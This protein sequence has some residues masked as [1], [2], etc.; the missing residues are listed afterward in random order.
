[1]PLLRFSKD[2][3]LAEPDAERS[4]RKGYA[5]SKRSSVI[6]GT[7]LPQTVDSHSICDGAEILAYVAA[8]DFGLHFSHGSKYTNTNPLMLSEVQPQLAP[9]PTGYRKAER[10]V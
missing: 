1:M 9:G 5:N 7:R 2:L 8:P 4:I 3:D 6:H 10:I